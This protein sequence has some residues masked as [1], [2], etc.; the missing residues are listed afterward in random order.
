MPPAGIEPLIPTS[1]RPQTQALDRA[2]IGLGRLFLAISFCATRCFLWLSDLFHYDSQ[3]RTG[4][5][6]REISVDRNWN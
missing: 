3:K 4:I 6:C 1:E 2:A 5:R